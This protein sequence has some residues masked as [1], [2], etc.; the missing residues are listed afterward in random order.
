M[1]FKVE[2][3]NDR[4]LHYGTCRI[5]VD[6]MFFQEV[7]YICVVKFLFYVDLQIFRISSQII[8]AI[9]L[10]ISSS[11]LVLSNMEHA[12]LLNTTRVKI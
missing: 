6:V 3:F 8:F 11:L 1:F 10:A 5:M 9:P 7:L 4:R 12:Y 2:L